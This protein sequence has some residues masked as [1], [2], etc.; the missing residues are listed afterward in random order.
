MSR[1]EQGP[2]DSYGP[3]DELALEADSLLALLA[4]LA[5]AL[6]ALLALEVLLLEL[7]A[8][9]ELDFALSFEFSS[10]VVFSGKL[11][12]LVGSL[13]F[14]KAL[15]TFFHVLSSSGITH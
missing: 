1:L 12:T 14:L 4:L 5:A 7:A 13:P 8:D 9:F 2:G 10:C 3:Y 6:E 15:I 11:T